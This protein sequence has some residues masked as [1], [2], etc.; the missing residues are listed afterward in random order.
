MARLVFKDGHQKDMCHDEA[1]PCVQN[2]DIMLGL[3]G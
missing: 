3:S 2:G 1:G